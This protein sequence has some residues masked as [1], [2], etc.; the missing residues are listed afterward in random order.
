VRNN[1]AKIRS[2]LLM[3]GGEVLR[4]FSFQKMFL[5]F[6]RRETTCAIQWD[7]LKGIE[8][9]LPLAS[10]CCDLISP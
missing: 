9:F 8:L 4:A 7:W 3:R 1:G 10:R 5:T 6:S 2:D